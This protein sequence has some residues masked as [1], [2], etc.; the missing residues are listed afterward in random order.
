MRLAQEALNR[1]RSQLLRT[2]VGYKPAGVHAKPSMA[3][4]DA[5]CPDATDANGRCMGF[6]PMKCV[7]PVRP[8]PASWYLLIIMIFTVTLPEPPVCC[9]LFTVTS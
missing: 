5:L 8:A 3:V 7:C 6:A 4:S 9:E 1:A 2:A